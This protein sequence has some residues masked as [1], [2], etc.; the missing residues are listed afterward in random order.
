MSLISERIKANISI[1]KFVSGLLDRV[2]RQGA[3]PGSFTMKTTVCPDVDAVRSFFG[4]DYISV[5]SAGGIK[6]NVLRYLQQLPDALKDFYPALKR[7]PRNIEQEK[8]GKSAALVRLLN[9]VVMRQPDRVMVAWLTDESARAA[10]F[11]GDLWRLAE[12]SGLAAVGELLDALQRGFNI[13]QAD[14]APLRLS[15]F[16]LAVT[17]DTKSCRPGSKLLRQFVDIL[18]RFDAAIKNEIDLAENSGIEQRQ[19]AVIDLTRLVID[20]AATQVLLYGDIRF[21]KSGREFSYI[22]EHA[23]LGEPVV[24]TWAQLGSASLTFIPARIVTIE[25]ETSFYDYIAK[26]NWRNEAVV[27]TMGQA[28]RLLVKLLRNAQPLVSEYCHWG[29]LDRSGVMILDSLRRRTGIDIKPLNMNLKTFE[30]HRHLGQKL[31]PGEKLMITRLLQ[32]RPDIVCHDLLQAI[33][34]SQLWIEQEVIS[35]GILSFTCLVP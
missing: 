1:K 23:A 8:A 26:A 21:R 6:L 10:G 14:E 16:G 5:D 4:N 34:D 31:K 2:D 19:R 33:A 3:V 29:D 32:R 17:G 12:E 35:P 24:V 20:G 7:S 22:S 13:L 25:N 11:A 15:H 18:Y 28:N 30:Q 9:E 27:C